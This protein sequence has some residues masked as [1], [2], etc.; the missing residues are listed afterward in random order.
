MSPVSFQRRI[1]GFNLVVIAFFIS[2]GLMKTGN[3]SRYFG[4]GRFTTFFSAAQLLAVGTFSYLTFRQR[5][6]PGSP[7]SGSETRGISIHHRAWVWLLVA[8]GFVFLAADEVGELHERMDR[9]LVVFL[10]LPRNAWTGRI[11]DAILLCY[12][13]IGLAV[14]WLWRKE[15]LLFRHVMMKPL[16]WGFICMFLGGLCDTASHDD[17]FF[18]S[19]TN[20][21]PLAKKLNG[22]F[23]AAE[24]ALTLLPEALFMSAFHAAWRQAGHP[25]AA[26]PA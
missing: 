17:Q 3:P 7:G 13:L 23:S 19:L 11:D 2:L 21:L 26:R 22:W 8:L 14:L 4:E 24:G 5:R 10:G 25:E 6:H 20:D 15:I 1:V 12:G 18:F 9:G 16:V